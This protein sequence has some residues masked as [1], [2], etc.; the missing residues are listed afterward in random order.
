MGIWFVYRSPYDGPTSKHVQRIEGHDTLLSWFQSIWR[1]FTDSKEADAYTR[2]LLGTEVPSFE[3]LLTRIAED[4]IPAP[5]TD[6]EL[7]RVDGM[8]VQAEVLVGPDTIQALDD[9]D[10]LSMAM[11][12]F[13]DAFAAKHPERVAYLLHA[14]WRLPEAVGPGGFSPLP[15]VR[16]AGTFSGEGELYLTELFWAD[17]TD[18]EGLSGA[19]RVRGM[20]LPDFVPWLLGLTSKEAEDTDVDMAYFL[21]GPLADLLGEGEGLEASF[22]RALRE[23]PGDIVTWNAYSDWLAE[24]GLPRAELRLLGLAIEKVA[25]GRETKVPPLIQVGPHHVAASICRGGSDSPYDQWLLFD[26]VWASGNEGLAQSIL[27]YAWRYDVLSDWRVKG[28][29]GCDVP[30]REG[31]KE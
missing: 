12:W 29:Y 3:Y 8:G 17:S 20:R 27:A 16:D 19:A 22:R 26:D 18:L 31:W 1:G 15:G 24:Q 28:Q 11:Y 2:E 5:Q 9:D 30:P 7:A 10:E 14:D 25:E 4:D 23:Q 21:H 13:T 6:G